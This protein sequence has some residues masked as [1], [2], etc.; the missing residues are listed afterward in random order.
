[1]K[2]N[3]MTYTTTIG[4]AS[5]SMCGELEESELS[6][7]SPTR[8]HCM[9]MIDQWKKH[10]KFDPCGERPASDDVFWVKL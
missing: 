5:L 1:M 2:Y 3:G 6:A 10:E 7:L 8:D 4:H 9:S